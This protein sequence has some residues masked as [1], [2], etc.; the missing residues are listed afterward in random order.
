MQ[1]KCCNGLGHEVAA[2][3]PRACARADDERCV[4]CAQLLAQQVQLKWTKGCWGHQINS[5]STEKRVARPPTRLHRATEAKAQSD[6]SLTFPE[7]A[8]WDG[9]MNDMSM[10]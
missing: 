10:V 2:A 6:L 1:H 3:R 7:M 8:I 9:L 4:V 5:H